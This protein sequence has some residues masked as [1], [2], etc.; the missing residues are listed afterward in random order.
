MV[1]LYGQPVITQDY[2]PRMSNS[3]PASTVIGL[4]CWACRYCKKGLFSCCDVTNTSDAQ[5]LLYGHNT[6]GIH[7]AIHTQLTCLLHCRHVITLAACPLVSVVH[8]CSAA[9]Q[10]HAPHAVI[11]E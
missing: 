5:A 11:D 1:L 3:R 10:D 9:Q 2:V 4:A 7:G 8:I 6:C